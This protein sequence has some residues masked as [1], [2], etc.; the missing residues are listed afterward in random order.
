MFDF[1]R[2]VLIFLLIT[3]SFITLAVSMPAPVCR[4][5]HKIYTGYIILVYVIRM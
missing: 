2:G 3:H 5:S 1:L 4:L